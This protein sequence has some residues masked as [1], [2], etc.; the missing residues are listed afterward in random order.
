MHKCLFHSYSVLF[1]FLPLVSK[2]KEGMALDGWK[3]RKIWK[4]KKKGNHDQNIL[5]RN[6][7]KVSA[8]F[9]KGEIGR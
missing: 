9:Q 2:E 4:E 5:E 7:Y 1:L 6:R 3:G 8:P